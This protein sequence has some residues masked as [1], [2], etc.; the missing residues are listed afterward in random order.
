MFWLLSMVPSSV[1][2]IF[3][4]FIYFLSAWCRLTHDFLGVFSLTSKLS[5]EYRLLR[6]NQSRLRKH[7]YLMWNFKYFDFADLY[8]IVDEGW[9]VACYRCSWQSGFTVFLA[10][11]HEP[12][13]ILCQEWFLD[14][15]EA[16]L[17]NRILFMAIVVVF[18]AYKIFKLVYWESLYIYMYI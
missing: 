15:R 7:C 4:G 1:L 16:D 14:C 17:L 2:Y 11:I 3:H 18:V 12:W 8:Y 9:A 5:V 10:K 6:R 13:D